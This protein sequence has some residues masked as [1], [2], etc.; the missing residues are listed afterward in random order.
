MFMDLKVTAFLLLQMK[1]YPNYVDNLSLVSHWSVNVRAK[2]NIII[3]YFLSRVFITHI[4][5]NY[6]W[7]LKC[8]ILMEFEKCT[9]FINGT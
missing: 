8:D 5:A 3:G 6:F 4:T 2:P 7:A 9:V 1:L